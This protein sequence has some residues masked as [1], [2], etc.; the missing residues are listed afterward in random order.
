MQTC[1]GQFLTILSP[2][3]DCNGANR[4]P[5]CAMCSKE[6]ATRKKLDCRCCPR[7]HEEKNFKKISLMPR[8]LMIQFDFYT[9]K[10]LKKR[11][12]ERERIHIF[13]GL[14]SKDEPRR[15]EHVKHL[16][17]SSNCNNLGLFFLL[18]ILVHL[19]LVFVAFIIII[20]VISMGF[21]FLF[22]KGFA[23]MQ[24]D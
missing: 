23:S 17:R 11:E 8:W 19:M 1:L 24:R 7:A 5:A 6:L 15:D 2:T 3:A 21:L 22:R 18:I 12:R 20:I 14:Q 4:V 10:C 13:F 9:K 16:L